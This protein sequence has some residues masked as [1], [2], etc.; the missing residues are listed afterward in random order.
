MAALE[1]VVSVTPVVSRRGWPAV[2]VSKNAFG[3]RDESIAVAAADPALPAVALDGNS[4][5]CSSLIRA[6]ASH[7]IGRR[8]SR[9]ATILAGLY[10]VGGREQRFPG[11]RGLIRSRSDGPRRRAQP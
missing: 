11:L 6:P 9:V 4:G 3:D 1:S 5:M 7:S 2:K 8:M 10:P